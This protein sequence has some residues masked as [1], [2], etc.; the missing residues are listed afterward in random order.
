[1]TYQVSSRGLLSDLTVREMVP[2]TLINA[3]RVSTV[4]WALVPTCLRVLWALLATN[5]VLVVWIS[6]NLVLEV[7]R[8][9]FL[10]AL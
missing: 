6:V 5:R 1:M 3:R 7:L 2:F 9:K 8:V 10:T 4:L